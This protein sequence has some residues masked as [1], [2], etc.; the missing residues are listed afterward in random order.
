MIH[1]QTGFTVIKKHDLNIIDWFEIVSRSN[2]AQNDTFRKQENYSKNNQIETNH[3]YH[4]FIGIWKFDYQISKNVWTNEHL[5]W[6]IDKNYSWWTSG[7]TSL[8]LCLNRNSNLSFSTSSYWCFGHEKHLRMKLKV[9]F[10]T[11][12]SSIRVRFSTY[13]MITIRYFETTSDANYSIS[14]FLKQRQ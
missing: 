12:S 11:F 4:F 5:K 9:K 10:D 3:D 7:T 14:L 6:W 13:D 8:V 2:F 1:K